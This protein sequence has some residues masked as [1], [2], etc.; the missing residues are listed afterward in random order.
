MLFDD[1]IRELN[2]KNYL[3]IYFLQGEETYYID[4]LADIFENSV[5]NESQKD[6]DYHTIYGKETDLE[7]IKL[8]CRQFPMIAPLKI[9]V[10]KEAQNIKDFAKFVDY[11]EKPNPNNILLILYKGANIDARTKVGKLLKDK[12]YLFTFDKIYDNKLPEWVQKYCAEKQYSINIDAS[13]LLVQHIGNNLSQLANELDKLMINI[14][15]SQKINLQHITDNIG[16][17]REYSAFELQKALA[18]NKIEHIFRIANYYATNPKA[19]AFVVT[20]SNL[21]SFFKKLYLYY[22]YN[23]Q[24]EADLLKSM[25]L[26]HSFALND[27]KEAA[28][29][30]NLQKTKKAIQLLYTY[31]LKSKGVDSV[32]LSEGELLKELLVKILLPK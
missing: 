30:F 23:H 22:F 16:I 4:K 27:Y 5:L 1:I 24:K 10:V 19:P 6:F 32:G 17:H 7:T 3:P 21:F 2:T 31:D 13:D 29:H 26:K 9:T 28:K 15:S 8:T 14:P 25:D 20:T 18:Q 11:V 12:K